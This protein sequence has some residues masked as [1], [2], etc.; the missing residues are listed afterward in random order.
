M[1]SFDEDFCENLRILND[2]VIQR[3]LK[4]T[5]G[6]GFSWI[7]DVDLLAHKNRYGCGANMGSTFALRM[8]SPFVWFFTSNH[9]TSLLSPAPG[10]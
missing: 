5:K 8:D 9:N 7:H 10:P 1:K 3:A 4:I 2:Q 6:T